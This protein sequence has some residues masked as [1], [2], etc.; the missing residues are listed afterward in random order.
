MMAVGDSAPG[1]TPGYMSPEQAA[2]AKLDGR[3]D[4]Y[5]LGIVLWELLACERL[6]PGRPGDATAARGFSAVP[7]PSEY[8]QGIPH[9]L[10]AVTM[11]LLAYHREARYPTAELAAGDLMRCQDAPRDGQAAIILAEHVAPAITPM[12]NAGIC[13]RRALGPT[14]G[15]PSQCL[16]LTV[17][18]CA[19]SALGDRP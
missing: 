14:I 17:A 4:L 16:C 11:R 9:R 1:G 13:S 2:R 6:R 3:S 7:Q 5:V 8:R 18:A 12:Q 15:H 10:E 19:P